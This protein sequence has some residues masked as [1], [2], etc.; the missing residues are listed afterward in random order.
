MDAETADWS[1][2]FHGEYADSMSTYLVT[3]GTA[4][5]VRTSSTALVE[6]GDKR[7][8]ARQS[9]HR[10]SARI[11]PIS[12]AESSSSKAIWSD[13]AAVERALDGVEIV[14]HQAALAS[15]PRSVAAPLDTNAVVRH[16]HGE[17]ARR[18]PARAA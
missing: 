6:R 3:G 9:Q 15:V 11:W 18:G 2:A 14:F 4:S 5:S 17:S 7:P 16:G 12:A 1:D 10:E 8:R 13:R